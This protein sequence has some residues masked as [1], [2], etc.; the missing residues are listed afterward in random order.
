MIVQTAPEAVEIDGIIYKLNTNWFDCL[1]IIMAFEDKNIIEDPE[2]HIH[3]KT[4]I[5]I[6]NLYRIAFYEFNPEHLNEAIRLGIKFLDGPMDE[7]KSNKKEPEKP[8]Y[9]FSKDWQYIYT[10]I[11]TMYNGIDLYKSP[12][13]HWWTFISYFMGI[14]ESFFSRLIHLRRQ[15]NKNKLS[16]DE[17]IECD[18]IGWDIIK[19][20]VPDKS[21]RQAFEDFLSGK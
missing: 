14:G 5:L 10:A 12:D 20:D 1:S 18:N 11:L 4:E 19:I 8:L 9:S 13:L 7:R 21:E 16:K 17:R 2:N 15:Y 6:E 3:E